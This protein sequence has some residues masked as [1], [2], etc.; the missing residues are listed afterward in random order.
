MVFSN[1]SGI[2]RLPEN[3]ITPDKLLFPIVLENAVKLFCL[4]AQNSDLDSSR[5]SAS[6]TFHTSTVSFTLERI[7]RGTFWPFGSSLV[8]V[9]RHVLTIHV[10]H[11][12]SV[13][14]TCLIGP[15][16]TQVG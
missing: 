15:T 14:S 1:Q 16:W 3:W 10:I 6:M 8:C 12:T 11:R 9:H 4:E 7:K 13:K 2:F 5:L